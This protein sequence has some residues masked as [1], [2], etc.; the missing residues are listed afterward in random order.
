[1]TIF[2]SQAKQ[3]VIG[4]IFTLKSMI[5]ALYIETGFWLYRNLYDNSF[6]HSFFSHLFLFCL[7]LQFEYF[8]VILQFEYFDVIL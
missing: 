2:F 8:D 5:T 4:N 7:H 1:M 3:E 6:T